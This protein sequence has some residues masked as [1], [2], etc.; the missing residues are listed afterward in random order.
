M[1]KRIELIPC[2]PFGKSWVHGYYEK[3]NGRLVYVRPY[4][5]S[6]NKVAIDGKGDT[7]SVETSPMKVKK[8]DLSGGGG[9]SET[10]TVDQSQ[11]SKESFDWLLSVVISCVKTIRGFEDGEVVRL[12]RALN[13]ARS[14]IK[15]L[16]YYEPTMD[17]YFALPVAK[18]SRL[19]GGAARKTEAMSKKLNKNSSQLEASL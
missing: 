6:K 1:E 16:G 17:G 18:S 7:Q 11:I 2:I 14:I 12:S 15:E 10:K 9:R 13:S 5:N 3:R 8:P 4:E 19:S